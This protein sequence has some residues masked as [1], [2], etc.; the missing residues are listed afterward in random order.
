MLVSH[1]LQNDTHIDLAT[2]PYAIFTSRF[3]QNGA[4]RFWLLQGRQCVC[5]DAAWPAMHIHTCSMAEHKRVQVL[6]LQTRRCEC[7]QILDCHR[8]CICASPSCAGK[9]QRVYS[10]WRGSELLLIKL[11]QV[12]TDHDRDTTLHVLYQAL[13]TADYTSA[14][15]GLAGPDACSHW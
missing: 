13:S 4:L 11:Q 3:Q 6:V 2:L 15:H 9:Q 7:R 12:Q 10:Q 5:T 8:S 1:T 14:D